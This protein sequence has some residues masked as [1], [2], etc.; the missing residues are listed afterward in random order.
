MRIRPPNFRGPFAIVGKHKRELM[1]LERRENRETRA[2]NPK[3]QA[4][5]R[6]EEYIQA[7]KWRLKN[8]HGALANTR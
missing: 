2:T 1:P 6:R 8:E 7:K 5:K 3:A 4:R